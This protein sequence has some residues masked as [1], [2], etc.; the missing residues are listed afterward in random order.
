MKK[1]HLLLIILFFPSF[2]SNAWAQEPVPASAHWPL[3]N[4]S[5]GGTGLVSTTSGQ[6]HAY[7]E[8]LNQMEINGYTGPNESQR[9]RIAGNE[10]PINQTDTIPGVYVEFK[11]TPKEGA[12]FQLQSLQFALA[13]ASINTMKA[14]AYYSL[15]PSFKNA[16][17]IEYATG[18]EN[19][20]LGREELLPVSSSLEV[21]LQEKDTFYLRIYPWVDQDPEVRTG[22][23]L[24]LQDVRIEGTTT[25]GTIYAPTV[26]TATE[27][28]DISTTFASS[29]GNISSDGGSPV[30]A[31]GI[32]WS[33]AEAPTT[34]DFKT[35][36]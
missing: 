8:H 29:G 4:P 13:A 3:T 25:G 22:K 14:G 12:T 2:W 15:E 24:T 19:N 7:E 18:N 11:V 9:L 10:W 5:A 23:Y 26:S 17:P 30:T 27:V 21:T 1:F 33:T 16:T 31:R 35:G 34:N 32:V 20:Y 6:L 36:D 28:T